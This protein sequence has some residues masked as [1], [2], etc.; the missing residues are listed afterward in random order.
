MPLPHLGTIAEIGTPREVFSLVH[1]TC[2]A[3]PGGGHE[4]SQASV[5]PGFICKAIVE[6]SWGPWGP[7]P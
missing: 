4:V 1:I 5:K 3:L 6:G 2:T 7:P